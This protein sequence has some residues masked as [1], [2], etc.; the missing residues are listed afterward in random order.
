[1]NIWTGRKMKL[2]NNMLIAALAIG[3]SACA[4]IKPAPQSDPVSQAIPTETYNVR[5][6]RVFLPNTLGVSE[7]N[8]YFPASDIVW[9]G[10][11]YGNRL[12]QVG[13]IFMESMRRGVSD[14]RGT[15]AIKVEV[16]VKRFHALTNRTRYTIGGN[17]SI[18]FVLTL[19]D[20]H[21]GAVIGV[22]RFIQADLKAFGG[23]RAIKSDHRGQT[24]KVRITDHL[25]EVFKREITGQ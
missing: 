3:L 7:A 15:R 9:R 6:L 2:I 21:T 16:E 1:M 19:R 13:T 11:P 22:P 10:D 14:L 18:H 20:A 8:S 24:Q 5:H 4:A 17:H 23:S 12:E 25:A